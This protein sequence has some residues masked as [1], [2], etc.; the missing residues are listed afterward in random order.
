MTA[1][2]AFPPVAQLT[3]IGWNEQTGG[4]NLTAATCGAMMRRPTLSIC[5]T[6]DPTA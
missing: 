4:T 6:G 3:G 2:C 1:E 5:K